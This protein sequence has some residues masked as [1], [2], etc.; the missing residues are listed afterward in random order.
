MNKEEITTLKQLLDRI[1]ESHAAQGR[2]SLESILRS[3]GRRSF[4]PL[5]L[6]AGLI[7]LAPLVGDIPGMPTFMGLLV[8]MTAGQMLLGRGHFWFPSW[9]LERTVPEDKLHKAMKMARK[10]ANFLDRWTGPRLSK[11][12]RGVW[13]RCIG[14]ICVAIALA[15]PVMELIPFSANGAGL[16]LTAFGLALIA[17]DGVL[18]LIA[19]VAT[20]ATAGTILYFLL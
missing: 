16:A 8:L 9:M 5:L 2:V 17:H 15:M 20:T 1:E 7:T 10:P 4:G 13:F 12:T 6:L 18:A 3:V 11:L 19:L 14:V